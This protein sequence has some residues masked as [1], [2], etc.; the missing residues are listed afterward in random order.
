MKK[1]FI[2]FVLA[3]SAFLTSCSNNDDSGMI[4]VDKTGKTKTY[5]LSAVSNPSISGTALF[6]EN[7][8]GTTIIS[9]NLTGTSS[10]AH[11]AHI[12]MN[13]AAE[14]GDIVIDLSSV[15]GSTGLSSTLVSAFNDGTAV[16]YSQLLEYDGISMCMKVQ[17]TWAR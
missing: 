9:L 6:E 7:E 10:G 17:R 13:T 11:P 16:T 5:D 12:H 8:D 2:L 4:I 3:A 15:D 14:S 1:L